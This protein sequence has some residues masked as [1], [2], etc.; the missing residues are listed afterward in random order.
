MHSDNIQDHAQY[1]WTEWNEWSSFMPSCYDGCSPSKATIFSDNIYEPT[2]HRSRSCASSERNTFLDKSACGDVIDSLESKTQIP[3]FVCERRFNETDSLMYETKLVVPFKVQISEK[4]SKN[5]KKSTTA[6][7]KYLSAL[8][9]HAF[10]TPL[11]KIQMMGGVSNS[12]YLSKLDSDWKIS[13]SAV[14]VTSFVEANGT[15]LPQIEHVTLSPQSELFRRQRQ[16][17]ESAILGI[18]ELI[19]LQLEAV[20]Y[21]LADADTQN[22]SGVTLDAEKELKSALREAVEKETKSKTENKLTYRI[23]QPNF[24][25]DVETDEAEFEDVLLSNQTKIENQY[26]C[27]IVIEADGKRLVCL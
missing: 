18:Y 17:K 15:A 12:T 7:F 27:K 22:V 11:Q 24:V 21:I 10:V 3:S 1:S 5:L 14:R 4:W 13:F 2:S 6:Y 26:N 16:A 23:G 9:S 20:F 19:L 25:D 8:Y